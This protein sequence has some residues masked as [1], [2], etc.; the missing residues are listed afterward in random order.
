MS[1]SQPFATAADQAWLRLWV[2]M[3][4]PGSKLAG[5]LKN[6]ERM[7]APPPVIA[8]HRPPRPSPV[9]VQGGYS[10]GQ[11]GKQV[12]SP[13][14]ESRGAREKSTSTERRIE[15]DIARVIRMPTSDWAKAL[16][17]DP[18]IM[19]ITIGD[20]L[21]GIDHYFS[22]FD[23]LRR[24]NK[25]AYAYFSRV[26]A[27]I[28]TRN[29][30]V[31]RDAVFSDSAR[32]QDPASLPSY[33]GAFFAKSKDE[34]RSSII[35]DCGFFE[36][37]LFEKPKNHATAVPWGTTV[38][39]HQM[40]SL[41]HDILSKEELKQYP[42]AAH[43]WGAWWYVGVLPNGEIKALP[44]RMQR[45]QRL[46]SGEGVHHSSF[47]I[48]PGLS[49]LSRKTGDPH[50]VVR[51]SFLAAVAFAAS[52]ISGVNVTIK[53]GGRS[54][55]IGVP[56]TALKGFFSDRDSEGRRKPILHLIAGHDRHM[57]DGRIIEVG[58]HLRGER[59]FSWRGYDITVGAPGIH[60]PAPESWTKPVLVDGDP[61]APLEPGQLKGMITVGQAAD[62]WGRRIWDGRKVPIRKGQ[63]QERYHNTTLPN[64]FLSE[65][66]E[67]TQSGRNGGTDDAVRF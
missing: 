59:Q 63:P 48:P 30:M 35:D 57:S 15:R 32:I 23:Q 2:G 24:V 13:R 38:F 56:I 3:F 66:V 1:Q 43:S 52:G 27:P 11:A 8:R 39:S 60:F 21:D 7:R 44:H 61:D 28:I 6:N 12:R 51:M 34:Y 55:R 10:K 62:R 40:I 64:D 50:Q 53:R 33:F 31:L 41:R 17:G 20:I 58:E 67:H 46:P 45:V 36:F 25:E 18:R 5:Y 22:V 4:G 37:E 14:V 29:T 26:G 16:L 49:K 47:Q 42:H 9:V 19:G 54:A 65:A